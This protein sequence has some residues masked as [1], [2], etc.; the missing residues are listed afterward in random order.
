[1][2]LQLFAG[3]A[4]LVWAYLLFG[5]QGFWCGR[6]QIERELAPTPEAWPAVI[7]VVPARDEAAYV[8][9]A[10]ASLLTQD[11]QGELAIVLVDDHSADATR[12]I[13]ESLRISAGTARRLQV[14]AAPA[15]PPGWSGKLWAVAS[16]LRRAEELA[17]AATYLLLTDADIAHAS[18]N[19]ARLVAKAEAER[20]D[21]VSLMVRLCCASFWERLLIP[22]FVFFFQ[23]LYPFP[24]ANDPGS[25]VAAA[26]GGCMLVRRQAL[27]EAGGIEA[28]RGE[29]IDDVA[30]ARAIKRRPGGGRIWL[31]L[32]EATRSLRRC[33]ALGEVW[34]MVARTADTQLRHSLLLVIVT[35]LG[36]AITYVVPPL[37]LLAGLGEHVP[38][39]TAVGLA[40]F[41][42]LGLAGMVVAYSAT[43][44]L[45]GLGLGRSLTLPIAAVLFAAM[46]VASA[47]EYRR[48]AGG[49]WKG[50]V[51]TPEA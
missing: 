26:A 42:L 5:R 20:L 11:Y 12:R 49:R 21:L 28:I 37:A 41:G 47:I 15:L 23:K 9:Q 34:A 46:T 40:G 16:G 3:L 38:W 19:L 32:S 35:L 43:L 4:L 25:R 36:L 39:L 29:L 7:A 22:P 27:R 6:P 50:R 45:Y 17:P 24:A 14:I 18:D 10:L 48:G 1:M 8:G 31:G 13:A 30:L 44:R 33:A 2:W 51:L